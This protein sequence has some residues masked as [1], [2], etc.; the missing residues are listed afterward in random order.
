MT[1]LRPAHFAEIRASITGNRLAV[2]E[3]L[4]AHG[5]ATAKELADR[6]GWDKCSVRPRI[7]ELRDAFHA[8]E[9]GER[10]NHE[11]VFAALEPEAARLAYA[12][13]KE[14]EMPP[15]AP[16]APVAAPPDPE[17]PAEQ[18]LILA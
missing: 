2:Y 8:V 17:L 4:L 9:T 1:D 3:A 5:P 16:A 7:C 18:L 13:A 10:R 6:M 15:A 14:R 12:S 11:H